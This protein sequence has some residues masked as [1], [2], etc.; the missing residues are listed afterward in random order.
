MAVTEE[1]MKA[2]CERKD[3]LWFMRIVGKVWWAKLMAMATDCKWPITLHQQAGS[4]QF[5]TG[6]V[7]DATLRHGF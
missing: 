6:A 7:P 3:C 1:L 4:R 2:T 5:V